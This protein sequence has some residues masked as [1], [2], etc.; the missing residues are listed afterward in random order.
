MA[1]KKQKFDSS[2]EQPAASPG[3]AAQSVSLP[4]RELSKRSG[5]FGAWTVV[6]RQAQVDEYEYQWEGQKRNGKT[7]SCILV[8]FDDPSEF[9]MG[10]MRWTK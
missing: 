10:Q 5:Q 6:V 9:C 3:S 2:A 7:F 4:L 1:S 8:S